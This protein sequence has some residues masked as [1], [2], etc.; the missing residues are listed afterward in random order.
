[1]DETPAEIVLD[2]EAYG[3]TD[4]RK[5]RYAYFHRTKKG[6]DFI[7]ARYEE[8]LVAVTKV[9]AKSWLAGNIIRKP[10]S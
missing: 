4:F 10:V 9:Q 7:T 5:P 6:D 8:H 1:M 3:K 2:E